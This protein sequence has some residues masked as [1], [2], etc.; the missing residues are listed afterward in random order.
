MA[1]GEWQR[2]SRRWRNHGC[3]QEL[4]EH[5]TNENLHDRPGLPELTMGGMEGWPEKR[6]AERPTE[7]RMW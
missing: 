6:C 5:P 2:V 4:W 7:S 1:N 3:V